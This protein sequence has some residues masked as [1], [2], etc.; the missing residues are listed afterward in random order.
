MHP[1]FG[2]DPGLVYLNHA[3]VSPWPRRTVEAVQRFAVENMAHGS[4]EYPAWLDTECKLKIQL[5]QL[6]NAESAD[7]IALLKSTSEGLSVVAHGLP[8]KHGD[9]VVSFAEEFPSNRYAWESLIEYGVDVRFASMQAENPEQALIDAC[10]RSTRLIAVS[11]VQYSNGLRLRIDQLGEFCKRRGIWLCVDAIQHLGALEFDA[12][13]WNVDFLAADGHKWMLGPEGLAVFY[14]RPEMRELLRLR[15]Y[16]WHMVAG[17]GDFEILNWRPADTAARFE[18]GSP[19]MLAIHA[20]HA[21]LSLLG[22]IGIR[23]I[24]RKILDNSQYIKNKIEGFEWSLAGSWDPE[25]GSGIVAF[26]VPDRPS[27]ESYRMLRDGN[28]AC[29]LRSGNIRFSPHFYTPK[30]DIDRAF[31]LIAP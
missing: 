13:A 27:T 14:C 12:R 30:E 28:V 29:A 20:L 7:D 6:L 16:G 24:E 3:A 2:L 18:C 9:S 4:S 11:S 10:D 22:E 21:S 17:A 25:R 19:N 31:S 8:W 5:A 23:E 26:R 1:E 15:Q